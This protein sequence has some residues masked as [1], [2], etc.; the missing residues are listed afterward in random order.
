MQIIIYEHGRFGE[1]MIASAEMLF[2]KSKSKS[3]YH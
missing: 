2:G 1:E 3:W